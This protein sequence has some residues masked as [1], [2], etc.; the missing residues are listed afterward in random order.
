MCRNVLA[1]VL[2]VSLYSYELV[3]FD[4]DDDDDD[5]EFL[6]LRFDQL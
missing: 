1:S 4:D 5:D 3:K 2:A 6:F